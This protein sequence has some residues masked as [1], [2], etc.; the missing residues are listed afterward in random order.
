MTVT[1][2]SFI[3]EL[4][5]D[6]FSACLVLECTQGRVRIIVT[7]A[8][9]SVAANAYRGELLGLMAIH[10]SL[11]SVHRISHALQGSVKIYSDCLG[12]LG[13]VVYLP[14]K[15]IPTRCRHSDILKTILVNF[16]GLSFSCTNE[17]GKAHHVDDGKYDTF[18][19]Q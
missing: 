18:L 14:T 11:L 17:H 9:N 5:P 6:F 15:R 19:R 12:E 7:F 13:R 2:G 4:L 1:D 10:L 16:S 3:R 8:E